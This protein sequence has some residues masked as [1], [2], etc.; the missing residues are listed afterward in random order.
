MKSKKSKNAAFAQKNAAF[1]FHWLSPNPVR[2]LYFDVIHSLDSI[3]IQLN[4]L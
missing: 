2:V 4:L 1:L 3:Q